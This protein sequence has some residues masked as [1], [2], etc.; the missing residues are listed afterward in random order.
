MLGEVAEDLV[1]EGDD[2]DAEHEW[3]READPLAE[4]GVFEVEERPVAHARAVG[5]VGV[6]EE[7]AEDRLRRVRR[8]RATEMPMRLARRT[9]PRMMQRL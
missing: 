7:G 9:P 1:V 3:E 8:R 6:E 2:G 5:A 4:A